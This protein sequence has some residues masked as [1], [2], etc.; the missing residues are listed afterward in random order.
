LIIEADFETD[1]ITDTAIEFFCDASRN[2]S[3]CNTSRLGMPD[4]ASLA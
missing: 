4:P 1:G 3:S 2:A